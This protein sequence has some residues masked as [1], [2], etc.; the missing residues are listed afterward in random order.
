MHE[1]SV[2]TSILRIAEEEVEKVK[3]KKV[4]EITLKIGKLSGVEL[5]SLK[6]AWEIC[7]KG[8]VLEEAKLIITEPEGK[9]Q[10]AECKTVFPLEK[11]Y[12]VCTNCKSPFKEIISGKELKIKKLI[13]I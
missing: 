2:A 3:G 12:D 11:I 9:A 5:D 6:F 10:C 4:K 13:I 8:S 7:M 1:L